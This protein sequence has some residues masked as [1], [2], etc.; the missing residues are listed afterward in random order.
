MKTS[1]TFKI[2]SALDLKWSSSRVLTPIHIINMLW[3]T[4][5]LL[6]E[7]KTQTINEPSSFSLFKNWVLAFLM[8]PPLWGKK[9]FPYSLTAPLAI[10]VFRC[11]TSTLLFSSLISFAF[12]QNNT[13]HQLKQYGFCFVLNGL[14][15][16]GFVFPT[17][18]GLVKYGPVWN[19]PW[20][21]DL[22]FTYFFC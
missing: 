2:T 14:E 13:S 9:S 10:N 17:W 7:M 6:V 22:V 11:A 8:V 20:L 4:A 16:F 18:N 5:Y 3:R 19:T 12:I 15:M 21:A 1:N